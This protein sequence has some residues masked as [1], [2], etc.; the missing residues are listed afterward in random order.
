MTSWVLKAFGYAAEGAI[1]LPDQFLLMPT[2]PALD[3]TAARREIGLG[4][5][6]GEPV[7]ASS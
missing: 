5:R 4:G 2:G 1:A 6:A 3:P 7:P